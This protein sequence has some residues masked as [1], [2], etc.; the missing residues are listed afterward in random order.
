MPGFPILAAARLEMLALLSPVLK[1]DEEAF[2]TATLVYIIG[3]CLA[4][5]WSKGSR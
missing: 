2:S 1:S 3:V 5:V 4:N